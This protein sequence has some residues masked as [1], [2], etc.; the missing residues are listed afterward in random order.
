MVRYSLIDN[1]RDRLFAARAN[2][3]F[4][5]LAIFEHYQGQYPLNAIPLRDGWVVI[6][7]QLDDLRSPRILL[8]NR[9]NYWRKRPARSTP[10]R[11]EVHQD[12]PVR[13]QHNLLEIVLANISDVLTHTRPPRTI[14]STIALFMHPSATSSA[15]W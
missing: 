8:C 12:K 9:F 14:S 5:F 4:L 6:N 3:T 13:L 15:P 2:D 1:A 11:L 10:F 7:V